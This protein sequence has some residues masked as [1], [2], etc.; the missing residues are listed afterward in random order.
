M[1]YKK[2]TFVGKF[3]RDAANTYDERNAIY[4]DNYKKFG[5]WVQPLMSGVRIETEADFTRLGILVH[6]FSKIS[7]Y[8]ENFNSVGHRDS[9]LDLSVYSAMLAEID[10]EMLRTEGMEKFMATKPVVKLHINE[11]HP[12]DR[13]KVFEDLTPSDSE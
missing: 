5:S 13:K 2:E 4:G 7:R 3:L 12:L 11:M 8:V 10:D 9:L 1:A 6:M